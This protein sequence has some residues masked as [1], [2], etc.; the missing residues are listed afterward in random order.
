M[1]SVFFA[2]VHVKL[3]NKPFRLRHGCPSI[4]IFRRFKGLGDEPRLFGSERPIVSVLPEIERAVNLG[5][6]ASVLNSY[7]QLVLHAE[8]MPFTVTCTFGLSETVFIH[9]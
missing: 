7:L 9:L 6:S 2:K 1:L 5:T 3:V 4:V 8:G